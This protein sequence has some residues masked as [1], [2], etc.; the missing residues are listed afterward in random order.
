L[1]AQYNGVIATTRLYRE[2]E[3]R[4]GKDFNAQDRAQMKG[5]KTATWKNEVA[6]ALVD[7][8]RFGEF[9][10]IGGAVSDPLPES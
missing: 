10:E 8:R 3:F 5:R 6:W 2:I 9:A 1:L 7:G 4:F